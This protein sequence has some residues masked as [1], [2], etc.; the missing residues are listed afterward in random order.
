M[1]YLYGELIMFYYYNIYQFVFLIY[2]FNLIEFILV[3]IYVTQSLQN[4][5]FIYCFYF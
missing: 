4:I 3:F 2:G 5:R 1:H